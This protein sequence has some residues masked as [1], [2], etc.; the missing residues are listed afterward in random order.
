MTPVLKWI[1]WAG[2]LTFI[3]SILCPNPLHAI[4]FAILYLGTVHL[5]V[6][7]GKNL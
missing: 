7:M 1:M 4:S 6:E 2:T 5:F 3:A